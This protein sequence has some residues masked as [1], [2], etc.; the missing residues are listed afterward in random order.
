VRSVTVWQIF[1]LFV[2]KAVEHRF[3]GT[4]MGP[5][6]SGKSTLMNILGCLVNNPAILLA[7]EPTGNL[8]TTS[9]REI[10]KLLRELIDAGCSPAARRAHRD[11]PAAAGQNGGERV[12]PS[13]A[14]LAKPGCQRWAIPR[15]GTV[16][17]S[18][19]STPN[20]PVLTRWMS[21]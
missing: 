6:G 14:Q 7:D 20:D 18:W 1:S 2:G 17:S 9:S 3:C 16:A 11:R 12:G 4:V 10:M 5:S 13:K 19:H 8:D 21:R 15:S